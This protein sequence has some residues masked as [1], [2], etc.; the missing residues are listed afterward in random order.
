MPFFR[1]QSFVCG[2]LLLFNV[3]F[4]SGVRHNKPKITN[5]T[6]NK[7][8]YTLACRGFDQLIT[9]GNVWLEPQM[10]N[11]GKL[12][13]HS[14][15]PF[16]A[17]CMTE[18]QESLRQ[19]KREYF[20][21][22]LTSCNIALEIDKTVWCVSKKKLAYLKCLLLY[23]FHHSEKEVYQIKMAIDWCR[24]NHKEVT[25]QSECY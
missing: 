8:H 13:V 12:A 14:R 24:Q 22:T 2:L 3:I 19:S 15:C 10:I 21:T 17:L 18:S 6:S 9:V 25:K 5:R 4:L 7:K 16:K 11:T 1:L 20:G 23:W